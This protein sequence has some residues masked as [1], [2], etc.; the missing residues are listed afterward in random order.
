MGEMLAYLEYFNDFW[1]NIISVCD[2]MVFLR[3]DVAENRIFIH[4]I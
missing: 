1:K 3:D 2:L 4:L